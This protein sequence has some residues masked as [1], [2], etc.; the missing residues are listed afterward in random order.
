LRGQVVPLS[1]VHKRLPDLKAYRL[2]LIDE[3]HNLR[4][5]EGKRYKVIADYIRNVDA[6][7]ILLTATPYNKTKTDLSSQLRLFIDE[8]TNIG[9]RPEHYMRRNA[10]SDAEF[11]RRWQCKPNTI[12]AIEKSDEFDD[13]RELIRLYMVRRT[14]SFIIEH[15]T[16]ADDKGRR[17]I[18]TQDGEKRYFP[19]R[20]PQSLT[21][22]I[23]E[24]DP[25][26]RY[27]RLYSDAVVEVIND[28]YVPRYGLGNYLDP[29]AIKAATREERKL[30]DN[31]GRAGK[32]LMG[33]CRTNLF[34]RLESSG[35]SFLTSIARHI[36]RN[37]IYLYAI[38]HGLD[39]PLGVLEPGVLDADRSDEDTEGGEGEQEDFYDDKFNATTDE[40]EHVQAKSVYDQYA[41][42]YRKRFKWITPKLFKPQLAEHLAADTASLRALLD[43]HGHWIVAAL[44]PGQPRQRPRTARPG[45]YRR[46]VGGSEPAGL[47]HCRQL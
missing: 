24:S 7:T 23:N 12:V 27:A 32:R 16:Q 38:T 30:V 46:I 47:Q 19:E 9:I 28:L 10:L 2:V 33:F 21:F 15:Y 40:A 18:A 17:Y 8:K 31:L 26:D 44:Q 11:E 20:R 22:P 5:R 4:N 14:R 39:L 42:M 41:A 36:L 37:E 13:W 45:L 6:R 34:K 35:D 43:A 25:K 3:S 1:Q 29:I